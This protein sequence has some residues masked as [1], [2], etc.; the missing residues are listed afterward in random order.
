M[1]L[2]RRFNGLIVAALAM[3]LAGTSI[4]TASGQDV[5]TDYDDDGQIQRC[6]SDA[7]FTDALRQADTNR[8]VYGAAIDIIEQRQLECADA[9]ITGGAA[10]DEDGGNR[11]LLW[12]TVGV[13][14]V[15]AVGA[16]A[17]VTWRRGEPSTDDDDTPQDGPPPTS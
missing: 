3:C 8:E 10:A 2:Q 17:Y 1:V 6:Y 7:D 14:L 12:G 13:L 16:A 15:A 5:L 4:A 11:A 9:T